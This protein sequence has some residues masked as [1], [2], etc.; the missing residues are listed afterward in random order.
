[1]MLVT[2]MVHLSTGAM[3]W[4][5]VVLVTAVVGV[6]AGQESMCETETYRGL[7][8]EVQNEHQCRV[9]ERMQKDALQQRSMVES[10][11][12]SMLRSEG[13]RSLMDIHFFLL[14]PPALMR[15]N[16]LL[17]TSVYIEHTKVGE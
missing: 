10:Q 15:I 14:V 4:Y 11:Y 1:M 6:V 8:V 13:H 12:N 7:P 9:L 17:H 16:L 3:L 2:A 5:V